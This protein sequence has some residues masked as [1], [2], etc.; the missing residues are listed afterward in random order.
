MRF[1]GPLLEE[2]AEPDSASPL[3]PMNHEERI[4]A[5][6]HGTGLTVGPHPMAYHR[7][8]MNKLGVRRASDLRNIPNGKRTRI[9]GCVIAR[10]RPGTAK[11]LMFMSIEDETGI[12]NA[13]VM[14]DLLHK[15]RMLLIS[16]NFLMVEGILQ[17]QD[18]VIH[19]RAE[20]VTPLAITRAEISSHDFH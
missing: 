3:Q 10:Q 12:A 18:N 11:G 9:G 7:E 8:A 4:I 13:I 16:E 15:N 14:P 6:F 17:N 19:I 5:D 20:P 1:S 2:L